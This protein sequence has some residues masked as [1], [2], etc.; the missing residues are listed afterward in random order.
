VKVGVDKYRVHGGAVIER[1]THSGVL[2]L[3]VSMVPGTLRTA[4]R[5][6]V[7]TVLL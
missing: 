5:Y 3:A 4:V 2:S 7:V 6:G 1:S